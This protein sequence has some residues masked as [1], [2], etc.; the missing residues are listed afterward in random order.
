M[1]IYFECSHGHRLKTDRRHAGKPS[2]CPQCRIPLTVPQPQANPITDSGVVRLLGEHH[3]PAKPS[4]AALEPEQACPRCGGEIATAARI[5]K[6]CE[7][8]L[9][10]DQKLWNV[11]LKSSSKRR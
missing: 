10:P 9:A 2:Q 11:S 1:F 4:F 6:H 3:A 8:Y 5:C 7:V